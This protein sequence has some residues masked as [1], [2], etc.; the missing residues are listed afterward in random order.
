MVSLFLEI[1]SSRFK[2]EKE[3]KSTNAGQREARAFSFGEWRNN[4]RTQRKGIEGI[5]KAQLK[6]LFHQNVPKS[7][8]GKNKNNQFS[9]K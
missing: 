8:E 9:N 2:L 3:D 1:Y 4:R 7:P 5:Q 6:P